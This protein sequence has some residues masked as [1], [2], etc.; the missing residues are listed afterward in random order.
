[1]G[2][3]FPYFDLLKTSCLFVNDTLYHLQYVFE[4]V[5]HIGPHGMTID[6]SCGTRSYTIYAYSKLG[7][8]TIYPSVYREDISMDMTLLLHRIHREAKLPTKELRIK[9]GRDG[10][11]VQLKHLEDLQKWR[12]RCLDFMI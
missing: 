6:I 3:I 4:N 1:M 8:I 11:F 12:L 7:N 2:E 10:T 9:L 5:R